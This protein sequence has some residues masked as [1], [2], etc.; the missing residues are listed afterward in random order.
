M[1]HRSFDRLAR[2]FGAGGS[3]RHAMRLLAAVGFGATVGAGTIRTSASGRCRETCD[4]LRARC[5]KPCRTCIDD[6]D[7]AE[8]RCRVRCGAGPG[9]R[10][11]RDDCGGAAERCSEDC[12]P[13]LQSCRDRARRCDEDDCRCIRACDE[14]R[15]DCSTLCHG[16]TCR[17]RCATRAE[18]CLDDCYEAAAT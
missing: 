17:K 3:R 1:D 5:V 12:A 8:G 15:G 4:D 11:C 16:D 18:R 10:E 9:A 13:C 2:Q 6:C 14:A 7:V